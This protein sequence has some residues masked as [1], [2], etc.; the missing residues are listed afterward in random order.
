MINAL[1]QNK[2]LVFI[3]VQRS[4]AGLVHAEKDRKK[5]LRRG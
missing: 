4:L 3:V 2:F 5:D 1:F